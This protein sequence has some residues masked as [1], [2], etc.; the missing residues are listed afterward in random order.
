MAGRRMFEGRVHVH[1]GQVYVR[2]G[3]VGPELPEAF[4]GQE[5]GLCGAAVP[6]ALFL[7]TGLHTGYV[8]FAVEAHDEP[9][10]IDDSWEEIV[11]ASF[12]AVT[13]GAALVEWGEA[14][15]TRLDIPPGD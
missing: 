8:G 11:E 2:A 10:P 13:P 4:A 12:A 5:N 7:I 1:Y 3:G 15:G 14:D 6:G 9:P